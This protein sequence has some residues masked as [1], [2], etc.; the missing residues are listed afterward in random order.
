MPAINSGTALQPS[1]CSLTEA[2]SGVHR[3]YSY[4]ILCEHSLL[5]PSGSFYWVPFT[6]SFQNMNSSESLPGF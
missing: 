6:F 1:Q 2:D 4:Y 5:T 3:N